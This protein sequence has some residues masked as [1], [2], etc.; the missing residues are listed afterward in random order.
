[1]QLI[2][3]FSRPS[4]LRHLLLVHAFAVPTLLAIAAWGLHAS[5]L[6]QQLTELLFDPTLNQF[7]AREWIGLELL[8][9][10]LA[11]SALYV[12]WLIL[13][14]AA[15]IAP[16]IERL[17]AHRAVLW[18]TVLAMAAGPTVVVA[19]K[20][21]NSIHCPWDLKEFGGSADI[22]HAWFVPSIDARHCFPGGHAAGGFSLASL[23]FAGLFLNHARL[24]Q[25]G[26]AAAIVAGT[27]FSAV[28]VLQGAHFLSH[29]LWAAAIDWF[30]AALVF[31]WLPRQQRL[32]AQEKERAGAL[33]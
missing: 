19:L 32:C 18:A 30:V 15:V 17:R 4:P 21:L 31:A 3:I 16:W 14:V 13:L 20:R 29:N 33:S 25:T 9:H 8:G 2:A 24:R 6:D 26:L 11:K 5:G 12:L 1:M 22:T 27:L 10:R 7:P 28:R 23:Y